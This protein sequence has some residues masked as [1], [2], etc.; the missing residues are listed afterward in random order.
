MFFKGEHNEFGEALRIFIQED[1][2]EDHQLIQRTQNI[3]KCES[4]SREWRLLHFRLKAILNGQAADYSS[5]SV[6]AYIEHTLL[7]SKVSG[8]PDL[9]VN[10]L[11]VKKKIE[12]VHARA[13]ALLKESLKSTSTR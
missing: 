6:V 3:N 1:H 11:V 7:K 9:P 12:E 13:Y 8:K 2:I 4:N 10:V 5:D